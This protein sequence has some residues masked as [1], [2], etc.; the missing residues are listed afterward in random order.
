M[1]LQSY[2]INIQIQHLFAKET[3]EKSCEP[4]VC[5]EQIPKYKEK[6]YGS[7]R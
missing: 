6:I 5:F 3:L 4:I 7:F 2:R 1:R